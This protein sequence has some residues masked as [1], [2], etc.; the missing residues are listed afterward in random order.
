VVNRALKLSP[1]HEKASQALTML[2]DN[3][4][5]P[6]PTRPQGGTGPIKEPSPQLLGVS[7]EEPDSEQTPLEEA[8]QKALGELATLFFEQSGEESEGQRTRTG[9]LKAIIDG[10]GPLF[11]KNFDK[12]QLMLHLG[13]VVEALTLGDNDRASADL[14]R[15][16]DIGLHHPAAY[17]HLGRLRLGNNRLESALRYLNRAVSHEDYALGSRLLM[18]EAFREKGQINKASTEYLEALSLADAQV[19]PQQHSDGLRQLYEPLIETHTQT[20]K[21]DQCD[22]ICNSIAELLNRPQWRQYLKKMR[23]ELVPI[24]EGPPTPLAEVL[25]EATSSDV[26][27]AMSDIRTLA[28]EGRRQAAFEEALFALQD[29]PTYLPLHIAIGDLLVSAN[30]IQSAVSKFNV[31]ARS[32]S[33]RGETARAIEMLR[34]VVNMSPMDLDA[35]KNLIDQLISR[36]Q[37]EDAI[38]EYIK[39]AEINYSLAEL[40]EARKVYTRA[41]RF[42]QQSGLGKSWRV[43]ILHRIADIDVQSLNWRQALTIYQ[44]ICEIRPD[45]LDA[46][47]SL[48]DLNFRLGERNQ[49][50]ERVGDFIH[51][52]KTQ[53]RLED[54][55]SFLEKLSSDWP[56]Q[57]VLKKYLA[58]Q[59]QVLNRIDDAILQLESAKEILLGAGN[60]D[61]AASM[62]R[63]I[64][65]LNPADVGKYK[66]LLE[67]IQSN[68]RK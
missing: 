62:I 12:T 61:G 9:G 16:I 37:S 18:A 35:R 17:F 42:A 54:L 11:A 7:K 29:A 56:Q 22:Q 21:D 43:R 5:L 46:N 50:L 40:L 8:E 24:D 41:L 68:N 3:V 67:R 15:V 20:A 45:D 48:I 64:I 26:V 34:R 2:R 44:Q 65:N 10:T 59:Y 6:K 30:Q 63:K 60:K 33:V 19:V 47:R 49:A 36:G 55:V 58:D 57:A 1:N 38:K 66:H 52:M 14:K 25:T 4:P 32:Y 23:Q 27:V 51:T 31:V 53:G 13:Q 39:M 28:R